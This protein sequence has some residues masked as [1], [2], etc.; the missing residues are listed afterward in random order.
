MG[1][2]K[3]KWQAIWGFLHSS[4]WDTP[5]F[6]LPINHALNFWTP[7]LMLFPASYISSFNFYRSF[8]EE[9]MCKRQA[10][11]KTTKPSSSF[12]RLKSY[13]ILN[14]KGECRVKREM[15]GHLTEKN[16]KHVACHW[17]TFK[18]QPFF[19]PC[20]LWT[21]RIW[22]ASQNWDRKQLCMAFGVSQVPV[23]IRSI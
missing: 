20:V 9:L 23:D 11:T 7:F 2:F 16:K 18:K 3:A 22:E 14:I 21:K 12:S 15:V 8:N 10:H 17:T 5:K 1:Y 4:T 6:S 19:L 13:H